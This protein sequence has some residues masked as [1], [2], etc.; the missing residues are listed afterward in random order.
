[1]KLV[2]NWKDAWKWWSVWGGV[3]VAVLS[4]V[5]VALP[6]LRESIS[7]E[8]F[9]YATLALGVAIP[10]LRVVSQSKGEA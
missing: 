3:I 5:Q 9:T 8:V 4:A 1:M 7:P 6:D 2:D 10:V